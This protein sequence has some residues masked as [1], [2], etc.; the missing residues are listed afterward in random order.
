VGDGARWLKGGPGAPLTF[1]I[2]GLLGLAALEAAHGDWAVLDAVRDVM[3]ASDEDD[4]VV[5]YASCHG[6]RVAGRPFLTM[7]DTPK[8]PSLE[9]GHQARGL[10]LACVTN[11]PGSFAT[12]LLRRKGLLGSF[13][14]VFGGEAFARRK[15]DPM[16]LL[17]TCRALGTA[18]AETWMVGDSRNDAEAAHAAGCP[19]VLVT[20]GYNHGEDILNV[21][22]RAH[23]ARLDDFNWSAS[24]S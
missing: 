24:A 10:P 8:T 12:E 11:K 20:Y 21:P 5:F 14:H 15:P 2:L 16:P 23:V 17:E 22:A 9:A 1:V 19:L 13:T 3:K 6:V 4:L 7:A 18:P